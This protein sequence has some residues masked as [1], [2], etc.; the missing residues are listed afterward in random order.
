MNDFALILPEATLLVLACGVLLLDA[1]IGKRV[2]AAT[3]WG[4]VV[5][6][7][8]VLAQ[9][10]SPGYM[11]EAAVF[12][13]A[14]TLRVDVMGTVLKSF[15]LVLVVVSFFYAHEYFSKQRQ[16]VQG[17]YYPLALFA[18]LGMMVLV[19]ANSLLTIYLGLE[20]LSL[21]L[22]SLVALQRDSVTAS[23]A[24]MKYFV[25]GALASGMLLY[26]MS[27]LYGVAGTLDLS[28]LLIK[29]GNL[30][31]QRLLL[32][33]GLVFL[34]VG[35]AFKLGVV[36]FHMW[37]PDVYQGA[38]TPVT[39]FIGTAPKL[40]AFGMAMR[41]L[42]DGLWGLS[43]HWQQMLIILSILS[44]GVGNLLA[45]AQRNFKRM[46]AYSTIA[47]MGFLLLGMLSATASGYAA[48]M[49]YVTLY[50]LMSM[51][52]FGSIILLASARSEADELSDLAGLAKRSPWFA[53]IL[54]ILMFS[55]AGVPPF[56]GFWAKWFVLKEVIVADYVWL[57][58]IA[59]MFSLVG[60]Y[61]YLR[62]VKLMYFDEP[63]TPYP[64]SATT[65]LKLVLSVNGLVVLVLGIVP[66]TLMS[67]CISATIPYLPW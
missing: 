55:M 9:V 57:A 52:A 56:G 43:E 18:T 67:V 44:M 13:F 66:S 5:S 11:P 36:P 20:L 61:Y 1:F 30:E 38:A 45:I 50:A 26:G 40:A 12:G 62:I 22:Y 32:T 27:M 35:I 49:F 4:A 39:Q 58:G 48:S 59:V 16:E 28:E 63:E 31:E 42:V 54:L 10:A 65:D 47:H 51:G 33:F 17:E 37:L 23:E 19:S 24:A 60:A 41:L 7:L 6:C 25:L 64:V 14:G 34:V 15:L 46:L 8:V 53:F 3:F 2:P 21:S 29:V